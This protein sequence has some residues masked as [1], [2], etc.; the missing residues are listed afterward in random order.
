MALR[1]DG[2][3]SAE[4]AGEQS[5]L[6]SLR[7]RAEDLQERGLWGEE[8]FRA[9]RAILDLDRDDMATAIRLGRCVQTAG[10]PCDALE[11][12]DRVLAA[13]PGDPVALELRGVAGADCELEREVRRLEEVGGLDAVRDAAS[14]AGQ[15]YRDL[16]FA[17]LARQAVVERDPSAISVGALAAALADKGELHT[18][19]PLFRRSL[20]LDPDPR[21]NADSMLAYVAMLREQTRHQEA[22]AACEQVLAALPDDVRALTLVTELLSDLAETERSHE[23]LVEANGYADRIWAQGITD[24]SVV[25][26]YDRMK[27]I[28]AR[29]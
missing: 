13:D 1:A 27:G 15:S 17:V 14:A 25:A 18:A 24:E 23:R 9:N 28:Y 26:L 29:I 16:R 3:N 21:A 19:E 6:E 10:R 20:E 2:P 4:P 11:L 12:F 8:A 22:V 7:E 5:E